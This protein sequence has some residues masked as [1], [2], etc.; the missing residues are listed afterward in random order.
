[1]TDFLT[2][3]KKAFILTFTVMIIVLTS[4]FIVTESKLNLDTND[5]HAFIINHEELATVQS[6]D[7]YRELLQ[8]QKDEIFILKNDT[9]IEF[10]TESWRD[11]FGYFKDDIKGQN[12]FTLIHPND[13]PY[14]ANEMIELVNKGTEIDGIGPFRVKNIDDE[15][16]LFLANGIPIYDEHDE[17]IRL[18]LILIDVSIPL[19]GSSGL[20]S[21]LAFTNLGF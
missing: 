7:H 14:F 8:N 5:L 17:I 1:M 19:S 6:E 9:T 2:K 11:N 21:E 20:P 16:H 3:Q 4:I 10:T 15:Y 18:G 13:L 12:F